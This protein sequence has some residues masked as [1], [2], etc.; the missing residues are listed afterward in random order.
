[1]KLLC[2]KQDAEERIHL[3]NCRMHGGNSPGAPMGNSNPLKHGRYTADAIAS[4]RVAAA[5]MRLVKALAS[6]ASER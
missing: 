2:D 4:R 6:M 3:I 1:M 5:S